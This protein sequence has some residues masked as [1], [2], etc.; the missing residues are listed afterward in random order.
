MSKRGIT[1]GPSLP[2]PEQ[3]V[4]GVP[5]PGTQQLVASAPYSR[6]VQG[7]S[8]QATREV[9][10]P[11]S[12]P[13]PSLSRH[14][15]MLPSCHSACYPVPP[16]S[17]CSR[18]KGRHRG[19]PTAFPAAAQTVQREGGPGLPFSRQARGSSPPTQPNPLPPTRLA[20]PPPKLLLA[21][22]DSPRITPGGVTDQVPSPPACGS[23]DSEEQGYSPSP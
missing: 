22:L 1:R 9:L 14:Q 17:C 11:L 2:L 15:Q 10:L 21:L 13:H 8:K 12:L 4:Q 3:G 5:Q 6:K 23:D 16:H 18:K 19:P 7:S 20:G